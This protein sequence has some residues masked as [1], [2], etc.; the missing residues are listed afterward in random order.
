MAVSQSWFPYSIWTTSSAEFPRAS[1][2]K[3]DHWR[4]IQEPLLSLHWASNTRVSTHCWTEHSLVRHKVHGR[5]RI[6]LGNSDFLPILVK[7]N[8]KVRHVLQS[9]VGEVH[10]HIDMPLAVSKCSWNLQAFSL[11]CRQP[12]LKHSIKPNEIRQDSSHC[13][14][15]VNKDEIKISLHY[16]I[17]VL[18]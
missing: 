1:R 10:F 11:Y 18:K 15:W 14:F 3:A 4:D 16:A 17:K 13:C 12:D 8:C 5:L 2:V 6:E 9:F 7:L